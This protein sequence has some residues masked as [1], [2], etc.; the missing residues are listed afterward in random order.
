MSFEHLPDPRKILSKEKKKPKRSLGQNF[1]SNRGVLEKISLAVSPEVGG[2]VVEVGPGL[3]HLTVLLCGRRDRVVAIEKDE[4][5]AEDLRKRLAECRNLEVF[6]GDASKVS[7]KEV[8]PSHIGKYDVVG[9]LPFYCST[10]ILFHF[11]EN[12]FPPKRIVFMFQRELAQ[13]LLARPASKAYGALTV[14][15]ASVAK[16][17]SLF[18]VSSGSFFPRPEV[19]A[20]VV[21]IVPKKEKLSKN[22]RVALRKILK[23]AFSGRRKKLKNALSKGGLLD[24]FKKATDLEMERLLTLRPDA[25]GPEDYFSMARWLSNENSILGET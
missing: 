1:L 15:C 22:E 4:G 10:Q 6:A 19:G 24:I 5:L 11:L 7:L 23:V 13:R 2:C 8:L 18:R 9:N 16:V 17:K 12:A 3:G 14:S 20:E 21:E 25:I